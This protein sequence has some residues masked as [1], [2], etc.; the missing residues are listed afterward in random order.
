M[1]H[2]VLSRFYLLFLLL[3][4]G[5]N[6]FAQIRY[7]ERNDGISKTRQLQISRL[8]E[9]IVI[10]VDS[11]EQKIWKLKKEIEGNSSSNIN[12]EVLNLEAEL[13][14]S[15]GDYVHMKL[16]YYQALS[17]KNEE[18]SE[19][20][21][22]LLEHI[23]AINEGVKG[24]AEKQKRMI[25]RVMEKARKKNFKFLEAKTNYSL[26]KY[27]INV[28]D[29]KKAMAHLEKAGKIFREEGYNVKYF[30]T[31]IS[32][33]ITSYWMEEY[34]KSLRY[35]HQTREFAEKNNYTKCYAHSLLNLAE[36]HLF[37]EDNQDS[38][39]YYF[40]TFL[41]YKD[42]AD[43]RDIFN[44]Y[45]SLEEFYIQHN[46]N[47][48]AYHYLKLAYEIDT[49]IKEARRSKINAEIDMLYRKL[50][51]Q[52][53]LQDEGKYQE[54]LKI[55][56]AFCGVFLILVI[57]VFWFLLNEKGRL[58]KTLSEQND[59]ISLKNK[60]IDEALKEKEL[61]LKEIH[62][63]VKNNLQIISSLLSL[64]TKNIDDEKAKIAILEGKERIQ[65]IALIHQK[66]YLD[67]SFATIEMDEYLGDLIKQLGNSYNEESEK[68][69]I[70]LKTNGIVLNIDT[71]VPLGLI[72]C[73]LATNAFKYAFD[74]KSEG[75]LKIE[76]NHAENG[77][78]VLNVKD[79]GIGMKEN[80]NFL[81]SK[82][83]GVEIV[84]ALTEQL[85]GEITYKSDD[86][87]T[88]IKIKF[89]ETKN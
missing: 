68:I 5:G 45:W 43:V 40:N 50:E 41:S 36:A 59:E 60:I 22:L 82:T 78:Y 73:E 30:E 77:Y 23:G 53:K 83:L 56:F 4:A 13:Y 10:D 87:G 2:N 14:R 31:N 20:Q 26:G 6:L 44:C 35:F 54:L 89:K 63:R 42:K 76:I 72:I 75:R 39:K 49:E 19:Y 33:G 12:I 71:V 70:S 64:Q 24:N 7:E 65:A 67:N 8:H 38:A 86:N 61:L 18:T 32:R 21:K 48:S 79:N 15:T 25:I 29:Y 9:L 52:R 58:N 34:E 37:I 62:H 1:K 80:F 47:D 66:L 74:N 51:D 17:F 84:T 3:L 55:I 69:R 85:D 27:Y 81:E 11:A 46:N 57:L 28:A 16:A 88:A